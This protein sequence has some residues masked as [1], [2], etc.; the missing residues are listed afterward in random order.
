MKKMISVFLA[1]VMM[2]SL[3]VPAFAAE[4]QTDDPFAD[5]TLDVSEMKKNWRYTMK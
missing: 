4:S 3:A 5:I 2:V 1:L